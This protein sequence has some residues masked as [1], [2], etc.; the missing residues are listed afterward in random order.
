MDSGSISGARA[1]RKEK[2]NPESEV[3]EQQETFYHD[4]QTPGVKLK[5]N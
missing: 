3:E 5:R 2:L 4:L 1:G